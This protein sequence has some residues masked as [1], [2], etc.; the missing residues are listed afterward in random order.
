MKNDIVGI[1]AGNGDL[2]KFII[3][4][5][6]ANNVKFCVISIGGFFDY[7]YLTNTS[8]KSF[9]LGEVSGILKFL[10]HEKVNKIVLA[11]GVEKPKFSELKVDL[12]GSVLLSK[13]GKSKL[14]G[15]DNI[16]RTVIKYFEGHDIEVVS[17]LDISSDLT[18]QSSGLYTKQKPYKGFED[19]ISIITDL[20]RRLSEFDIGQSLIVQDKRVIGIEGAEGTD[21]LINRCADYVDIKN[22]KFAVM[23]KFP[24]A[25]QDLRVDL[26]TIGIQTLD[27]LIKANI[28]ILLVDS[29]YTLFINKDEI[30]D[31]ANKN[32]VVIYGI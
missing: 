30:L 20:H 14:L 28:K 3:R 23:A 9:A 21:N 16:L 18:M 32:K 17:A 12:K 24:K 26:P 7:T 15:D 6:Q 8:S 22:K 25:K 5:L 13:I 10:K 29:N 11:G 4:D 2:P 31:F 1:I 27:N 19:D